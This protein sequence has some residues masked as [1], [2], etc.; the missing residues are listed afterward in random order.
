MKREIK[1]WVFSILIGWATNFIP[2]DA[3]KTWQWLSQMPIE[4]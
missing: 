1:F 3:T 4:K 2:K